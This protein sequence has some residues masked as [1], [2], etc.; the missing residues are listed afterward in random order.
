VKDRKQ[1]KPEYFLKIIGEGVKG[2]EQLKPRNIFKE[3][4]LGLALLMV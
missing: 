2:Q 1:L 4:R 3:G